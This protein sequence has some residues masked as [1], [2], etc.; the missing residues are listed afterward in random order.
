[1]L[2]GKEHPR[3]IRVLVAEDNL[4]N[5]EIVIRML[6]LEK[7]Y[8]VEIVVAEDGKTGLRHCQGRH[9]QRSILQSYIYG[10]PS[11]S[12]PFICGL[13]NA[14]SC[15]CQTSMVFRARV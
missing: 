8:E 3:K 12:T 5:Q 11:M 4:V 9:G 10:Y 1:M 13:F 2:N 6:K 14:D 15:R 7:I